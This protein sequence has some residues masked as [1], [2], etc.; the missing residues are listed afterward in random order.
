MFRSK[1]SF[2]VLSVLALVIC[3]GSTLNAN[4][5]SKRFEHLEVVEDNSEFQFVQIR[6]MSRG[7]FSELAPRDPDNAFAHWNYWEDNLIHSKCDRATAA[8]KMAELIKKEKEL[9]TPHN[10]AL[11]KSLELALVPSKAKEGSVEALIDDLINLEA[12]FSE[13]G[14]RDKEER[15]EKIL[16][17]GYDAVPALIAHLKDDRL[18]RSLIWGFNNF[19]EWILRV[20][21]VVCFL[22]EGMAGAELDRGWMGRLKGSRISPTTAEIWWKS[23]QKVG[24]EK[25]LLDNLFRIPEGSSVTNTVNL[26]MLDRIALKYPTH[27]PDLYR[28]CLDKHDHL[29]SW[30]FVEYIRLSKMT[31]KEKIE[32]LSYGCQH[33]S[34]DHKYLALKAMKDFDQKLFT[35]FL[36]KA[37][38]DL[39]KEV[40]QTFFCPEA[41]VAGLVVWSNDPN[42]WQILEKL[43][44]G[45]SAYYKIKIL[46][47]IGFKNGKAKIK[48]RL[49]YLA[50]FL[51]AKEFIE[52]KSFGSD[53]KT[54]ALIE[55]ITKTEVRNVA[56]LQ[57]ANLLNLPIKENEDC[58]PEEWAKIRDTVQKAVK[59]ELEEKK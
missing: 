54:G 25:Y 29:R 4:S 43:T 10:R 32:I 20:G 40:K 16:R 8:K 45:A 35:K 3:W 15:C 2:A 23:A 5:T 13:N 33:K 58:T 30:D 53:P 14:M 26:A 21:D 47:Q 12:D 6:R 52:D 42:V 28:K 39:P 57:L 41:D 36:I 48:E 46:K 31:E 27:L 37:L 55:V 44:T 9:D 51:E 17:L 56:A 19:R 1:C 11:L 18:T 7:S 38:E 34:N 59:R 24:E 50:V 49:Q 22:L